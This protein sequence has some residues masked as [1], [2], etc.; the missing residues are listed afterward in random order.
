MSPLARAVRT[1][2]QAMVGVLSAAV[3]ADWIG[4]LRTSA[5]VFALGTIA[6]L[7]AAVAAFLLAHGEITAS[8]PIGKALA[9]T[10]QFLGAGLAT[11]GLADL[12]N[13]A[14]IDFGQAV[15]KIVIAAV[16]TGLYTLAQNGAEQAS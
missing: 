16:A 9:S 3:V 4:D 8:T 13:A 11:V 14:A 1:F 2:A 7:V 12:T 6:A 5:T 15:G 10:A